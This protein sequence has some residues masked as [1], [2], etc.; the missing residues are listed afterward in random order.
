MVRSEYFLKDLPQQKQLEGSPYPMFGIHDD[1]TS[2]MLSDEITKMYP[3][4]NNEKILMFKL[5]LIVWC[6]VI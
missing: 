4:G 6:L 2:F 1:G 5:F 3:R